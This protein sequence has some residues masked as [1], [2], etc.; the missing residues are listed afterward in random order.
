ML[1]YGMKEV[2]RSGIFGVSLA[3]VFFIPSGC[4]STRQIG[5]SKQEYS[6]RIPDM[7][8]IAEGEG[9]KLSQALT[10]SI[11][12]ESNSL[13]RRR[14]I[15]ALV[16]HFSKARGQHTSYEECLKK[17]QQAPE[18]VFFKKTWAEEWMP[19]VE[20]SEVDVKTS[21]NMPKKKSKSLAVNQLIKA[22]QRGEWIPIPGQHA[23]DYY[24]ALKRMPRWN[25]GLEKATQSMLTS[26]A[27][28]PTEAYHYM[29]LKAEENFPDQQFVKKSMSL[30]S[31]L[32]ECAELTQ[33]NQNRY[34]LSGRFRLGLLHVMN[35]DCNSASQVFK[36]IQTATL[37]DYTTRAHYWGAYC[38]REKNKREEFIANYDHLFKVNPLGFHTLSINHGSSVLTENLNKPIDPIVVTRSVS[39]KDLNTWIKLLEEADQLKEFGM[40]SKLL[41]LVL[42]Y[43]DVLN[44][45]EPGVALY[46]ATFAYRANDRIALFRVLDYV[47]RSQSV[48]VIESTMKL[49]YPLEYVE[50][51]S[52]YTDKMNPL[53]IAALIRQESAFNPKVRSRVGAAG[54]MQLMPYTAHTLDRSVKK[55]DLLNPEVNI[56]LG[57]RYF[58]KLVDKFNGD[59]E[60]A[61]AGY[62]AGPEA[63]N[64]WLRRYP[65]KNKLLF[66][67]LIP[68]TETRN[69][70]TLIGRNYFW[71][72]QLYASQLGDEVDVAQLKEQVQF[73]ALRS[74][75]STR[76]YSH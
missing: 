4:S 64:E 36:K 74:G 15:N 45:L 7:N 75:V 1:V 72:T 30:Y 46:L 31:K 51:I 52:K 33:S 35:D 22:L 13:D 21:W 65:I 9:P 54:L 37:N 23:G 28:G 55:K 42:K 17:F 29:A 57:V 62:N 61:L 5:L 20:E 19:P 63:V 67:D 10:Q 16:N 2:L 25:D 60:L 41:T 3:L 32:D 12:N 70:V 34:I 69:Y 14:L 59:V 11:K 38:A 24:R 66:L 71:Y 49:F 44:R 56:R 6:A 53:M 73:D 50:V 26:Q 27:C 68:Y 48:Y 39:A 40:V 58:E 18:C 43:P 47:F 76:S 8:L